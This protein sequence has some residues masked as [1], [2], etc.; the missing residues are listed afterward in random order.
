MSEPTA[1]TETRAEHEVV[2]ICRDLIRIDTSNYGDDSGPGERKA[3]EHVAGLLTEVGL[4]PELLESEPRRANVVARIEGADPARPALLVHGHLD[5]VPANADDW[6]VDPFSGEVR[7]DCVWGRGAVDMKDMD[8]MMLAVVRD[9][10]RAGA[11]PPRDLVSPSSPTR[12]P[13]ATT[14]PLARDN[15]PD[16]FEGVTE[17]ISEVGGF[18]HHRRGGQRALPARR[19]PRRASLAAAGR[20]R[21][22]RARLDDQRRQRGHPAGRGGRPDRR[23]RAGRCRSPRP[24]AHSSTGSSELTGVELDPDDPDALVAT[25]GTIARFVGAT[26]RTP[27]TRPCSTPAT[28]TTSSRGRRRR[29]ST[30]ASCPATRSELVETVGEL[31]GDGR[32]GRDGAPGRRPSR[33]RSRATWSTR[34]SRRCRPRTRTR[35]C[36]RTA[37]PGGTDNK[38]FSAARHRAA[39]ASRRCGCRADLDF[40]GDV[41]RRRRAGA[42]RLAALRRPGSA[43][44][45]RTC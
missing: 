30:A 6:Q 19:P 18:S 27:P 3:A 21:P 11:Q 45:L 41:P 10:A 35:P 12:R 38:A 29:S 43:R 4:E 39:T 42:G 8:A 40:A 25:L 37:C 1:N 14:A 17:A 32:R 7:D 15:R 2:D 5:V 9:L 23:A 16:L 22:G 34:W 24:S 20:P 33:R 31:A 26:L 44:F 28:S 36:C 13:A